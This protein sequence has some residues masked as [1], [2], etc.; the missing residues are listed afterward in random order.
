[1]QL[2]QGS[3]THHDQMSGWGNDRTRS[4]NEVE[5]WTTAVVLSFLI[6]YRKALSI[7]LQESILRKYR[8]RRRPAGFTTFWADLDSIVPD[9]ERQNVLRSQALSAGHFDDFLRLTD[10]TPHN[11]IVE[12]V[13]RDILEPTL[14][15]VSQ[16]PFSLSSFLLY[17]PP[18]TRKTSFVEAIARE[19]DWPLLT[20][21]PPAFL[22]K[23]IEGFEAA[24]DEIFEDL[25]RLERVVVLFDECEEFFRHRP[26]NTKAAMESRTIGA[27]ITS[28]MLPRLQRLHDARWIVFV[29]NTNIEAFELDEA[30]TRRG[31]L[32][33]VARV[34]H[35]SLQAQLR[36]LKIWETRTDPKKTLTQENL[37][38]FESHLNLVEAEMGPKRDQLE[39]DRGDVQRDNPDRGD[40]Y[41]EEMIKLHKREAKEL[42]KVVTFSMLDSL[43]NRC[44][45]EG[46]ESPILDAESLKENLDQEFDRFGPDSWIHES[47][48]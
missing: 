12:G 1:V 20:L 37:E 41:R 5:S 42:K 33:M 25:L 27:F 46:N 43:A 19:L 26:K 14:V 45:G 23:G 31:R 17:G 24:A 48:R 9:E 22:K 44:L 32:D 38:W 29:I 7:R 39:S 13:R 30:V 16:R 2:V 15:S 11:S 34:G 21:S 40:E 10:P 36:Y 3:F 28:G 18:G 35:P 8:A 47:P 6:S 4:G